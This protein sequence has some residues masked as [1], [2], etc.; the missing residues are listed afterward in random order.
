MTPRGT[1]WLA[2]EKVKSAVP[3]GPDGKLGPSLSAEEVRGLSLAPGG[4]VVVAA[5]TAVRVGA[6]T[7]G[8]SPSPRTS[9]A[10]R[11]PWTRSPRRC[12]PRAEGCWW[13]TRSASGC[14]ATTPSGAYQAPFPDAR[15]REVTRMAVGQRGRAWFSSTGRTARCAS[16]TRRARRCAALGPAQRHAQARGRGRGR[17][18][19]HVRRRRGRGRPG[20]L[21]AGAAAGHPVG[22]QELRKPTAVTVDPAGAVLVYDDKAEK[23]LRFK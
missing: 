14:T 7:S 19:E 13:P 11:S 17:L 16:S 21:A 2:S 18:P 10:R 8:R 12:S 23:V 15:E 5:K 1:L 22:A 20:V 6:G 3:V 4:E 9:R